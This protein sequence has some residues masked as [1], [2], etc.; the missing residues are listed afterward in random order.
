[1]ASLKNFCHCRY[2][3]NSFHWLL[4][5]DDDY[6]DR[7]IMANVFGTENEVGNFL[8]NLGGDFNEEALRRKFNSLDM[9]S[10][11]DL[12]FSE[13]LPQLTNKEYYST[14][15]E[16]AKWIDQAKYSM[17]LAR[18]NIDKSIY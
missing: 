7:V 14:F 18:S 13:I 12:D 9:N 8:L 16:V 3:Q 2:Q 11:G 10:N 5:N 6:D 4:I 17:N 1:M 15:R